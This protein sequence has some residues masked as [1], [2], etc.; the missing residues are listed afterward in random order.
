MQELITALQQQTLSD[1]DRCR[2]CAALLPMLKEYREMIA[3]KI[4]QLDVLL[5]RKSE[6]LSMQKQLTQRS[7][8]NNLSEVVDDKMNGDCFDLELLTTLKIVLELN[9]QLGSNEDE[10]YKIALEKKCEKFMA[11]M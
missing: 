1:E 3:P 10:K 2:I 6:L 11:S 5:N 7:Q 8:L 4:N 9:Q